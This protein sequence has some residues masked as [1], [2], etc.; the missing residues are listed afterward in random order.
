VDQAPRFLFGQNPR[1]LSPSHTWLASLDKIE[2]S[3]NPLYLL[4]P[5]NP[6][7]I[8]EMAESA[9]R[10][11]KICVYLRHLRPISANFQP[12]VKILPQP[13]IRGE[14]KM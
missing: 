6:R 7:A 10:S 4:N 8:A 11:A 2:S 12:Q 3:C 14:R 5:P 9:S 13:L 1:L